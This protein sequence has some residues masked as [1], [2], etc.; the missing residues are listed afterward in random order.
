M[1]QDDPTKLIDSI[2]FQTT[3]DEEK[4]LR[5]CLKSYQN[6]AYDLYSDSCVAPPKNC[7]QIIGVNLDSSIIP[8]IIFRNLKNL[9][10]NTP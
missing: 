9:L 10:E 2:T 8:K 6:S 5:E 7:F 1:L 3:P 4:L